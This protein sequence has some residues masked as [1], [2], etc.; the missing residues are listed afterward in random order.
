MVGVG[1]GALPT[2]KVGSSAAFVLERGTATQAR[3]SCPSILA[4]GIPALGGL[5]QKQK[6]GRRRGSPEI[7]VIDSIF[8]R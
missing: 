4:S 1:S 8:C 2:R 5:R 3:V 7:N 6:L